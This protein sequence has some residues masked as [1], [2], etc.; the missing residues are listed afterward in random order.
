M[1]CR[2]ALGCVGVKITKRSLQRDRVGLHHSF[3]RPGECSSASGIGTHKISSGVVAQALSIVVQDGL[4]WMR[5]AD[6]SL[7]LESWSNAQAECGA[8]G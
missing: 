5:V 3:Y 7:A 2:S 8:V 1:Q 4:R 6:S